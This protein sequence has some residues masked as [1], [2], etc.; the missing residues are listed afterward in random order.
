MELRL[1]ISALIITAAGFDSVT[2]QV[3]PDRFRFE[4][5]EAFDAR[6]IPAYDASHDAIYR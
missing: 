3:A 6:S 1:V 4:T 2:A 5:E